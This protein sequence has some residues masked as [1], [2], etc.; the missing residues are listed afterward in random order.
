MDLKMD[1]MESATRWAVVAIG[2]FVLIRCGA[3]DR[4]LLNPMAWRMS[5]KDI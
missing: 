2:V 5:F 3:W 4:P 1:K